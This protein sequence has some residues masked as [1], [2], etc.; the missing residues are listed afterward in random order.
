MYKRRDKSKEKDS[1]SVN[2]LRF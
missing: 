1:F 2:E